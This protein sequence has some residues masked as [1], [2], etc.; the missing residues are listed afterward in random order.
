MAT[1]PE[2]FRQVRDILKKLDRSIDSARDRRLSTEGPDEPS[3]GHDDQPG[4][5]LRAKP[6]RATPGAD[7]VWRQPRP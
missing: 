7:D 6:M 3:I 1:S 4:R 2:T 5:P